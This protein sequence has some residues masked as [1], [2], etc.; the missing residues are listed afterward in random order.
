MPP[1]LPPARVTSVESGLLSRLGRGVRVF[2]E[3]M[4]G[5]QWLDPGDPVPPFAPAEVQIR[6]R[7]DVAARGSL[8]RSIM[9]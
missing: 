7:E 2:M 1:T 4:G 8:S 9:V 6:R 3:I 5:K